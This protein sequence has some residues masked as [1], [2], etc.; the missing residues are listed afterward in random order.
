MASP[1]VSTIGL[2]SGLNITSIVDVLVESDK[3]AKQGQIDRAT[4]VNT[5][6]ISGIAKLQ[7][8][9]A[10]FQSTI[11]TLG[12]TTSPQFN[13]FAAT[14]SNDK[15]VSAIAS[16][17]AVAGTYQVKVSNLATSSKV[18]SAAFEGGATSAIPTGDMKISQN[19]T[20]YKLAIGDG[21]TLQSVRD[22]I[23]S[24][25]ALK[26][27]GIS[28][29][30]VTDSFGSRLVLGSSK[31]G[32]GSDISVE[33]IA[34]LEI[35]GKVAVTGTW[36]KESSGAIGLL[37]QDASFSVDGLALTS[38]SNTVDKA[39]SGLTLNLVAADAAGVT[40]GTT[41]TVSS[42]TD[43]LKASIQKFVDAYNAVANGVS[44]LTKA[45]VGDD[46][47]TVPAAMTGDSL[48]RSILEAIRKPLFEVGSGTSLTVLSQLGITTNQKTG[49]LD[50]DATK[51]ATAMNDKKLGSEVQGLF[52]GEKG[53]LERMDNT[54]KQFT[55]GATVKDDSVLTARSK[56]LSVTKNRL[57]ADQEALD[58]RIATLT[59]VLTKKYTA[60][61]TLVGKLKATA[62]NITSMFEALTAQQKNS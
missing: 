50:F 24:D 14:S 15:S 1:I 23:N 39:I 25:S 16:N 30:I 61:D 57:T 48:P 49:A 56:A 21:A 26:A 32:L 28:A 31:T 22:S 10:T 38:S 7:S 59:D 11:K 19:G 44:N 2:G 20:E 47:V 13:G 3:A 62:S 9:M 4:K 45:T 54:V 40:A 58:R 6:N 37:A 42:N 36:T 60:M 55:Q 53:L 46:G 34:G 29:N 12:S 52:T 43:G 18:A 5:A 41:V 33:G 27:A 17:T 51:F 8:L 35:N